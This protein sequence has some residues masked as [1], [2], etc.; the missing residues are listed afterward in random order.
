MIRPYGNHIVVELIDAP[1]TTSGGLHIPET[2]QRED[3]GG[4]ARC[5][6][7]VAIGPGERLPDGRHREIEVL[8]GQFVYFSRLAGDEIELNGR[9]L[10]VVNAKELLASVNEEVA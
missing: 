3:R 10:I 8:A 4:V 7:V 5:G 6:K 2:G 9:K 1:K